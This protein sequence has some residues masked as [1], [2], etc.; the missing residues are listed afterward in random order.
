MKNDHE[1]LRDL[2]IKLKY[3]SFGSIKDLSLRFPLCYKKRCLVLNSAVPCCRFF[4][5]L[6]KER[7]ELSL[8]DL[9]NDIEKRRKL[10]NKMVFKKIEE[11][12]RNGLVSISLDSKFC[13]LKNDRNIMIYIKN[14]I[15]YN[16]IP[17]EGTLLPTWKD[18]ASLHGY[19]I[20]ELNGFCKQNQIRETAIQRLLS[21]TSAEEQSRPISEFIRKLELIKRNDM[22]IVVKKWLDT[23]T[24][25]LLIS[26]IQAKLRFTIFK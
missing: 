25:C 19:T 11:D 16:L 2:D 15:A 10:P 1:V 21:F 12:I 7:K 17:D 3:S 18:V 5:D 13:D 14:S 8:A 23:K 4:R 20:D 9:K 24:V 22:V 6:F 26:S